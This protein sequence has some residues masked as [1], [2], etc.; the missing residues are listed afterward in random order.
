MIQAARPTLALWVLGLE[1]VSPHEHF[2]SQHVHHSFY[3][4]APLS[5]CTSHTKYKYRENTIKKV[6]IVTSEHDI[7]RQSLLRTSPCVTSLHSHPQPGSGHKKWD[8]IKTALFI[9]ALRTSHAE[10]P[11]FP[12]H[13]C[14]RLCSLKVYQ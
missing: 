9:L 1:S 6:K 5:H 3:M 13:R 14:E 8:S 2:L 11:N 12:N 7:Q 10:K 4:R